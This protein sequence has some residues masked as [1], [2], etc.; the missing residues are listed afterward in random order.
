MRGAPLSGRLTL[1]WVGKDRTLLGTSDGGYEWVDRD[2]PRVVEVRLLREREIVGEVAAA[3]AAADNLLIAGDCYDA[4]HALTR[5]P[6]YAD[7]LLGKVKLVYIDPP[8]NTGQAFTQYDD[9]LEHSV[10]LTMMRDRLLLIRELLAPD[11]SVWVHLDDAEMAY[12]RV[13]L[14]EIFGRLNFVGTVIWQRSDSPRNDAIGISV[15]HDYIVVFARDRSS[16]QLGRLERTASMNAVYRNPDNDPRGPWHA[17][18]LTCNKTETERSNLAYA[19][20]DPVTGAA[21]P[22]NPRR[23]WVYEKDR[24]EGLIAD[25]RIIFPRSET[26]RPQLKRFLHELTRGRAAQT[27][28][29]HEEVGHTRG[30]KREIQNLFPGIVPFATP[31]PERLLQRIIQLGSHPG[32]LV[33]DCFAGS[34]T[35]A[36]VAHKMGRRWVAVEREPE[37]FGVFTQPRLEKVIAGQ[38]LYGVSAAVG[39]DKGGGFRVLEVGPSMY[40][41]RGERALLAEWATNGAFAEGVAAQLGFRVEHDAPFSGRKGRSRL[42]VVDGVLDA[43][44]VR[45]VVSH[46]GDD[47]RAVLVGKGVT[48]DAGELLKSLSPGS[49]LRKAPR[50]LL[51]RGIVR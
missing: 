17:D 50:D 44:V 43:E 19:I 21:Y 29:T 32:D 37:T 25:G 31:K 33:L 11:G 20:V 49:R 22:H 51:K 42:A 39:W 3:A 1:S 40:E 38:D 47:E 9:A 8:F 4:L 36:A 48:P 14:D 10:W 5:I 24:M 13:L 26:G 6:E 12:C 35:T 34:G 7:Q 46:L 28:W 41:V 27:V 23:V 2:D 45:A 16:F 18:N 15:D 30:S